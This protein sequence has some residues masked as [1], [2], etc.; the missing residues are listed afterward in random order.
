MLEFLSRWAPMAQFLGPLVAGIAAVFSAVSARAS[1]QAARLGTQ[2]REREENVLAITSRAHFRVVR[3]KTVSHV[4]SMTIV[5]E[6]D[7]REHS[8]RDVTVASVTS[9]GLRDQNGRRCVV[10]PGDDFLTTIH[11]HEGSGDVDRPGERPLYG[12]FMLEFSDEHRL[13]RWRQYGTVRVPDRLDPTTGTH[14]RRTVVEFDPIVRS[15]LDA[16]PVGHSSVH[17]R[18]RHVRE[19]GRWKLVAYRVASVTRNRT[20]GTS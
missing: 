3:T 16:Q 8:A 12:S 5:F 4:G 18:D 10:A 13:R 19:V 6:N 7:D 20:G 11:L 17:E 15:S 9:D 14:H 2:A 1:L